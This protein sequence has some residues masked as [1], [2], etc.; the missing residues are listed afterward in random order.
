MKNICEY[1]QL[2]ENEKVDSYNK[3]DFLDDAMD[4]ADGMLNDNSDKHF[5][6]Y[7]KIK[8]DDD[9]ELS[10]FVNIVI[11][12]TCERDDWDINVLQQTDIV[13]N[14]KR[15]IKRLIEDEY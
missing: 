14:L 10:K 5:C 11:H 6:D 12:R 9:K 7:N 13:N 3:Q 15:H 2:N 1:L 4:H 8:H